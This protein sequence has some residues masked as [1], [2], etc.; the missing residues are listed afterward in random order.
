MIRYM[1]RRLLWACVLF[2]AV[3]IVSYIL[4]YIIPADPAKQACGQACTADEVARVRHFL[5]L[6]RPIYYQYWKFLSQ[7]IFHFN[8][9]HSYYNR[10]SVNT[11]VGNAAPVTAS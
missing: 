5:G 4:F 3:T 9:G 8:L 10:Q 2:L 6:D 1:I 11:L 7:L